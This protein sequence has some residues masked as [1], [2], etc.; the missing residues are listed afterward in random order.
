MSANAERHD[1]QQNARYLNS[2]LYREHC[3][4]QALVTLTVDTAKKNHFSQLSG[5]L[6][7]DV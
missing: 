1:C 5:V 3:L 2:L 4:F 7:R 6:D